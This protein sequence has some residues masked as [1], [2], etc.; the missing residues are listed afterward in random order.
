[1]ISCRI[2][3]YFWKK[4]LYI[5]ILIWTRFDLLQAFEK[6]RIE[7]VF[8]DYFYVWTLEYYRQSFIAVLVATFDEI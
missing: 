3:I 5:L 4:K 6:L 1:M 2:K 7:K 8:T